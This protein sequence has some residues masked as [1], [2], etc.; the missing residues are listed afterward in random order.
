MAKY[1][2]IHFNCP[3]CKT[4]Y[5]VVKAEAGSVAIDSWV[6]PRPRRQIQAQIFSSAAGGATESAGASRAA[7]EET[8]KSAALSDMQVA[9]EMKR[10]GRSRILLVLLA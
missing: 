10:R 2:A 9:G 5:H 4:L 6:D 7:G 8:L 3:S 1:K